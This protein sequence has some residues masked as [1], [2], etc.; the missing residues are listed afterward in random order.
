M[1]L[2]L[3][4]CL[5]RYLDA[6][7]VLSTGLRAPVQLD[8]G[9]GET[10]V[11][12]TAAGPVQIDGTGKAVPASASPPRRGLTRAGAIL[13]TPVAEG[14]AW[15]DEAG[16]LR[17]G[18]RLLI[19]SLD[20]PRALFHD[21]QGRILVV[22][23]SEEPRLYRLEGEHLVLLADFVGPVVDMAWGPGGALPERMLYLVREDGI[24]EYL[25]PS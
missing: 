15:V 9:P 21:P 17:I 18:D 22:A 2:L 4:A 5:S 6:P 19:R 14:L 8:V 13:E 11:V 20:A 16:A 10:L 1:V 25:Q 12:S 24:L 23:G 3:A 7:Y